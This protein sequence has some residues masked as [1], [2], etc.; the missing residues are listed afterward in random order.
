VRNSWEGT[1]KL[2]EVKCGALLKSSYS[3]GYYY[4]HILGSHQNFLNCRKIK[5]NVIT[6]PE[7]LWEKIKEIEIRKLDYW[8]NGI[9]VESTKTLVVRKGVSA[10]KSAWLF[11]AAVLTGKDSPNRKIVS[12][13]QPINLYWEWMHFLHKTS[14]TLR[15]YQQKWVCSGKM[16]F[17]K[18]L[19]NKAFCHRLT[20]L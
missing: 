2:A 20:V 12:D 10:V 8:S 18:E 11:C 6:K 13:C 7:L 5:Y 15:F 4:L 1:E 14:T 19:V 9:E 3:Y 16:I 17:C